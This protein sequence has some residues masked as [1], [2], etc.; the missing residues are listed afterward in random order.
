MLL[1][2]TIRYSVY[3]VHDAMQTV[4]SRQRIWMFSSGRDVEAG[5]LN[6]SD[7]PFFFY[8][9]I[10]KKRKKKM[11]RSGR[12][13][14]ATHRCVYERKTTYEGKSD[15]CNPEDVNG[16]VGDSPRYLSSRRY[17]PTPNRRP[18]DAHRHGVNYI[19]EQCFR[20]D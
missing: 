11:R 2:A 4:P 20:R 8:L 16:L 17:T 12:L 15:S 9:A 1:N 14:K 3:M 13:K 6:L 5:E 10:G 19:R 7:D 18:I